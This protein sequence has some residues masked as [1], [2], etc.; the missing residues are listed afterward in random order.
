MPRL[1]QVGRADTDD[2][3]VHG[4]YDLVFGKGVN[5]V[6]GNH[7]DTGSIGDWWTTFALAP[8]VLEHAVGGFVLYRSP[9]RHL[10]PVLRELSLTRAG[11]LC[12]STFVYSQHCKSLR[13]LDV[14]PTKIA[15]IES[16]SVSDLF[17]PVERAVL[18]FTDSLVRDHGRVPDEVFA[19]LHAHLSDEAVLELAYVATLYGMHAAIVRGLRLEWD[20]IDDSVHEIDP[21]EGFDASHFVNMGATDDTKEKF[22]RLSARRNR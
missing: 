21:P 6:E 14:D 2:A 15:A 7:T 4:M 19:A 3:V 1:R 10:D 9:S 17:D 11:W 5:P 18:A 13:G 22:G 8:D 16:W 20:D 12:G